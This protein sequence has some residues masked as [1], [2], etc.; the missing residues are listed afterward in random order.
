[1]RDGRAAP[2]YVLTVEGRWVHA[3][4]PP[5]VV[6]EAVACCPKYEYMFRTMPDNT[7]R[8]AISSRIAGKAPFGV[9]TPTDFLDLGA[10]DA[11]DKA[12]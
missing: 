3:M 11:V 4:A 7:L 10:R 8:H 9:W 2:E 5:R 1:L 6:L 12:L